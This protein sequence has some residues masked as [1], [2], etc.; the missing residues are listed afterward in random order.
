MAKKQSPKDEDNEARAPR[1]GRNPRR[2][3]KHASDALR[4]MLRKRPRIDRFKIE[5]PHTADDLLP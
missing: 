2:L 4:P 3:E 1:E 5:I